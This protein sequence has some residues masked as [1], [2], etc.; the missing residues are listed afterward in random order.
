MMT[1][2]IDGGLILVLT[3]KVLAYFALVMMLESL[4]LHLRH[5]PVKGL[6][7]RYFAFFVMA[8]VVMV[9]LA[10]GKLFFQ[11]LLLALSLAGF[12]EFGRALKMPQRQQRLAV[13]GICLSYVPLFIPSYT[14]FQAVPF[15]TLSLVLVFPVIMGSPERSIICGALG[16][17]SILYFGWFFAHIGYIHQ[18]GFGIGHVLFFIYLVIVND[19]FGYLVGSLIGRHPL[20]RNISP[21]K[22]VE[23][24]IG[25]LVL[26]NV[27]GLLSWPTVAPHFSLYQVM[28]ISTLLSIVGT[29]GDLAMASF[30]RDIGVKDMAQIIPGHG[31]LLDRMNSFLLTAPVYFHVVRAWH[32]G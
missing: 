9:P 5:K 17:L 4:L 30:K 22:T 1:P 10:C 21:K 26:T 6:W 18:L 23:G 8:P 24:A 13:L 14:L 2:E 3:A 19:A 12:R 11:I 15:V 28:A 20:S 31:G 29:L 27:C 32:L 25:A 7:V 16:L